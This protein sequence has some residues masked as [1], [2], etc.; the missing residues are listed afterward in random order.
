MGE[1][2]GWAI[3]ANTFDL[4]FD[5]LEDEGNVDAALAEAAEDSVNWLE[6]ANTDSVTRYHRV[7]RQLEKE[8]PAEDLPALR[9]HIRA[10][11]A[12]FPLD[13]PAFFID[14]LT[15]SPDD[16]V[17]DPFAGSNITGEAAERAE[18]AWMAFEQHQP[19][20]EGSVARFDA[21]ETGDILWHGEQE[22]VLDLSGE[23]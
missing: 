18:R 23:H 5:P 16:L 15:D 21:F 17:V 10:H 22:P 2:A 6:I 7:L 12:R 13:L 14:F 19:Y 9:E 3:P 1:G 8:T 20:L 11:P 4:R